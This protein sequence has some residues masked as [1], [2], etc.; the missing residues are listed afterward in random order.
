LTFEA[1]LDFLNLPFF[2]FSVCGCS[3]MYFNLARCLIAPQTQTENQKKGKFKKSKKASN[4]K[5]S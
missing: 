3:I 1:F 4:V 5:N 2:W